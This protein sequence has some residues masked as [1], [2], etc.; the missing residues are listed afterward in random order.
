[1]IGTGIGLKPLPR[2][3][4]YREGN[5]GRD[6]AFTRPFDS[7]APVGREDARHEVAAR[8]ASEA[9]LGHGK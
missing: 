4:A 2:P 8:P 1:M 3:L 9:M 5:D 7:A 6:R